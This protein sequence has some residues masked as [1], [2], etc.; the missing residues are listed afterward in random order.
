MIRKE[1]EEAQDPKEEIPPI[2]GLNTADC[3][4]H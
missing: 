3:G 2:V 1:R 4:Y